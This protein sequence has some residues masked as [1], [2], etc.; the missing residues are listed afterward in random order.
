MNKIIIQMSYLNNIGGI[1]TAIETVLR[2]FKGRDFEVVINAMADGGMDQVKRYEKYGK[3]VIDRDRNMEHEADVALIFTPILQ[4]VPWNTIKARKIYQFIHS[5]IR[6][7]MS[8][9][10]WSD[11]K[12]KPDNKV[13][14]VLSVSDT[15][16]KA[17]KEA[18]GV[19]SI[20]VPNIFNPGERKT[21]FLF[22]GR[23]TAEKGL[24]KTLEMVRKFDEAGKEYVLI[25]ASRID[26]YG[27]L[28]P[29]ISDNPRIIYIPANIN[30]DVFYRC[31]DYLCML[32]TSE[33][34]CYA[35]REALYNGCAVLGSRI[36]EIEKVVKDGKNGYLINNDLSDLDIEKIFNKVPKVDG[37]KESIDPIWDDVLD[38]KL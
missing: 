1:E 20:V 16:Q 26:P 27:T 15:A 5:D 33:S 23:A 13:S 8:F 36:P 32:S 37:Y 25:L 19:D 38:G 24:D 3:V 6:G 11:F 29:S 10:Q 4:Q 22:M 21:V 14:R 2:T 17:L 35:I 12:W 18:Q 31:A 28:W 9:P 34:W 7:M 30:N